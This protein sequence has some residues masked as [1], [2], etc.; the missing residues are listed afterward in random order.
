MGWVFSL[1]VINSSP[2]NGVT[3][4]QGNFTLMNGDLFPFLRYLLNK[5]RI[6][7]V[8]FRDVI[9]RKEQF[10]EIFLDEQ[11]NT[12]LHKIMK[13][14]VSAGFNGPFRVDHTPLLSGD[15]N[16]MSM[17]GYSILGRIDAVGFL[18]GL[19]YSTYEELNQEGG[20]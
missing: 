16:L 6:F 12:N 3:F 11:G 1:T 10:K 17:P 19:Y 7:F 14:Y 13:E 15:R 18:K 2:V 20:E 5:N 4:C 9:G 8:H